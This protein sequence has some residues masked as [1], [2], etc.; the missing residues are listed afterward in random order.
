MWICEEIVIPKESEYLV[1]NS[2]IPSEGQKFGFYSI[3]TY[4]TSNDPIPMRCPSQ[5]NSMVCRPD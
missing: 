2:K 1:I 4:L 3:I 5:Y